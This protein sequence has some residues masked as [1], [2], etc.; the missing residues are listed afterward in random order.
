MV[1]FSKGGTSRI[2]MNYVAY[3]T[4]HQLRYTVLKISN[5]V[6]FM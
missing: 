1:S 6:N 2:A 4:L 5:A 3:G